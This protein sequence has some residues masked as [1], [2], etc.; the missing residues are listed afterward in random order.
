MSDMLITDLDTVAE[1]AKAHQDAFEVMRY[2]LQF[3]EDLDDT[4]LDAF[5]DRLATPIVAAIDC[6]QCANCCHNLTVYLTEDDSQRLGQHLGMTQVAF[7][8][9]YID[10][11]SAQANDEWGCFKQQPCAL[12][13]GKL[14]S[15]YDA[16]PD[17]CRRYPQFTP[18]FR[19]VLDDLIEGAALCPI[20]LNLLLKLQPLVD[21]GIDKHL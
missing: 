9:A 1:V 14:C 6:T 11:E 17:S 10:H 3:D 20:I 16:R 4:A 12:L 7:Q 2:M 15:V 13:K 19:W 21:A 18:D 5:I 8:A